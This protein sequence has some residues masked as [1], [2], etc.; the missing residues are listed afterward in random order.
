[1]AKQVIEPE[2]VGQGQVPP[3]QKNE[4]KNNKNT[5]FYY[6]SNVGCLGIILAFISL[7]LAIPL[8]IFGGVRKNK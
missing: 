2:I 3:R 7:A 8:A 5:H 6:K 1:M 4:Q